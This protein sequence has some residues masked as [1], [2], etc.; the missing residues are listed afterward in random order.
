MVQMFQDQAILVTGASGFI[1]SHLTRRLLGLGAQLH[2]LV[3]EKSD[4]WRLTGIRDK[5]L[6]IWHG[7]LKDS[8]GLSDSLKQIRPKRV[9]HLGAI[10]NAER[11][12]DLINEMVDVNLKGTLNLI[13]ALQ[14]SPCESVIHFGTCEEYG[15]LEA[16]FAE[17][18]RES[19]VSPYSASKVAA[20]HFCQM[21]YRTTGIPIITVRPF[22]TYGPY[23]LSNMFIPSLIRHCLEGQKEFA[24]TQGEQAREFNFVSDIVEGALEVSLRPDLAGEIIN[25]GNGEEHKIIDVARMIVKLSKTSLGLKVGDLSYRAGEVIHFHASTQKYFTYFKPSLITSLEKG[26]EMTIHWYN[27]YLKNKKLI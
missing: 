3:Q 14:D 4:L 27:N 16:P 11:N 24:M 22:L 23:Q 19:P 1:A 6:R 18:E 9:F 25:L 12:L 8:K 21:T 20:T 15:D 2:I 13:N 5:K 17:T 7:N 10:V 26:L